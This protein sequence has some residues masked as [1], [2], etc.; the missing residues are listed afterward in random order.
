MHK[1]YSHIKGQRSLIRILYAV[2]MTMLVIGSISPISAAQAAQA[3]EP[4]NFAMTVQDPKTTLRCGQT[5][6]YL[7]RV[8]LARSEGAPTPAPGSLGLPKG[9]SV[10]NV[11]V[12]AFSSQTTV[13]DFVATEKGYA[14]AKTSVVFDNDLMAFAAKFKFKANKP[15]KTT[16]HFEGLV[17]K[18]YVSDKVDVKVLPCKFKVNTISTWKVGMTSVG[19]MDGEM[20]SDEQGNLSG[21]ATV[22]WVTSMICGIASPIAPGTADLTGTIDESGQLIGQ[23]SFGPLSSSGGGA[24]GISSVT[25]SNFG[26]LAPLTIKASSEGVSVYTQTQVLTAT[27]GSF[28][29]TATIVVIPEEDEAVAF[30]PGNHEA[31]VGPPSPWWAMLWDKFPS[32][33]GALLALP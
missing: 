14:T 26:T 27:N 17:G 24:C 2:L 15:G 18:E 25:T 12:E 4:V 11:K 8:G 6:T 16:L 28:S 1:Q 30:I 20:E 21:S 33:S 7:V 5:V 29:G 23:V 10:I 13:G 3:G 9:L 22:N 31:R 32:L 19:S